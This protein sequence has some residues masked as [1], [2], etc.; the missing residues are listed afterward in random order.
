MEI[1]KENDKC[2]KGNR[3]NTTN[4]YVSL[5]LEYPQGCEDVSELR[6]AIGRSLVIMYEVS[7][8]QE[9]VGRKTAKPTDDLQTV[10]GVPTLKKG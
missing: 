7:R 1:N 4:N 3:L 9:F 6:P 5:K 8:W 2:N 10:S